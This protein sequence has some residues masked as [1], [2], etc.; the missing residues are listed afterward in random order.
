MFTFLQF[1][2]SESCG[3][4]YD[5]FYLQEDLYNTLTPEDLALVHVEILSADSRVRCWYP[6]EKY[7]KHYKIAEEKSLKGK[8]SPEQRERIQQQLNILREIPNTDQSVIKT[9]EALLL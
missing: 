2:E 5:S 4:R 1:C 6:P 7:K 3:Q 9:L 8:L